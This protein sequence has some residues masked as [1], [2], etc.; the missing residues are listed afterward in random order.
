[1]NHS[2]FAIVGDPGDVP[3]AQSLCRFH[4]TAR[5]AHIIIISNSKPEDRPAVSI[6]E[7]A[8]LRYDEKEPT[9]PSLNL[10][11]AARNTCPVGD[12][13]HAPGIVGDARVYG[14]RCTVFRLRPCMDKASTTP[15]SP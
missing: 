13:R 9:P 3:D 1:M 11:C 12:T 2:P 14:G 15:P 4:V 7:D 6:A 8:T 5:V 10:F